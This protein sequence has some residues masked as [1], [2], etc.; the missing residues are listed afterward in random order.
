MNEVKLHVYDLSM[1]MA[2]QMSH[3]LLGFQVDGIWHTGVYVFGKE[4]FY[5]GVIQ[6]QT[7][8]QV[9]A[10]FGLS[11]VEMLSIGTT[12]KTQQEFHEFLETITRQ[13]TPE[14]YNVFR[15]N[16]NHFSD[17]ATKFLLNGIGIPSHI[18]DLPDRVLNTP[19]GQML[20]PM[21]Q[22]MENRM[23]EHM[24]PFNQGSATEGD[25][26][27]NRS[28]QASADQVGEIQGVEIAVKVKEEQVK[29]RVSSVDVTVNEFMEALVGPSG[30]A[31]EDQRIIFKGQFLKDMDRKLSDYGITSEMVVHLVPKPDSVQRGATAKQ[32]DSTLERALKQMKDSAS[33]SDFQVALKTILKILDNVVNYPLEPKYRKIKRENP[34]LL[35]RLGHVT[36]SFDA[37]ISLG[38]KEETASTERMLVL[39]QSEA[40]WTV[41]LKGRKRIQEEIS[42][43]TSSMMNLPSTPVTNMPMMPQPNPQMIQSMMSNPAMMQQMTQMLSD[44][45]ALQQMMNNPM[46]QQMSQNNPM[47]QSQMEMMR[48]NPQL[49][50]NMMSDPMVQN[51]M[52]NPQAMQSLMGNSFGQQNLNPGGQQ[53][54]TNTQQNPTPGQNDSQMSEEEMLQEAIRRSLQEQ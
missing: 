7:P 24:I 20:E 52:R 13:Y 38:F 8:E 31:K 27:Q 54:A 9:K 16:C 10:Q 14:T 41:L 22:G 39:E 25:S 51:M 49:F 40:A 12:S 35:K 18:I 2:Q 6:R 30:Y 43:P 5:G 21:Y 50:Q 28:T 34:A 48:Q 1:G 26:I 19:M 17:V 23:A 33:P 15:H 37:L 32:A 45:G 36:G 29:V 4:Y 46:V 3:Q 53:N 42:P 44:P 11:P 47:L